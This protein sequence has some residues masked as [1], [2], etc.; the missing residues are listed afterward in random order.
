MRKFLAL[1]AISAVGQIT[2]AHAAG[3]PTHIGQCVRTHIKMVGTR[4]VD[5]GNNPIAGSGSAVTFANGGY[6]VSYEQIPAVD[7]SKPGDPARMCLVS[8]PK[9][10]PP[11]DKRGRR[12]RTTNLRTHGHWLLPDAEHQCGGA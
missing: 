7:N 5:G 1:I 9:P 10:C 11:G 6:Q 3:L 12:Y 4:L 2:M 8:I